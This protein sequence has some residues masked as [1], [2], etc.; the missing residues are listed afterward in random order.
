MNV[1]NWLRPEVTTSEAKY[2]AWQLGIDGLGK[3]PETFDG[4]GSRIHSGVDVLQFYEAIK[5]SK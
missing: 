3:C 5:P 2:R 4:P 1:M